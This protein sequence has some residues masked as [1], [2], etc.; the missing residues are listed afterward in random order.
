VRRQEQGQ[1]GAQAQKG[2]PGRQIQLTWN[3]Y[4]R[5]SAMNLPKRPA[6]A[7][8]HQSKGYHEWCAKQAA[9]HDPG[10]VPV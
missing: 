9:Y 7:Y 3:E 2:K 6:S 4:A 1:R 5:A 10:V 8:G